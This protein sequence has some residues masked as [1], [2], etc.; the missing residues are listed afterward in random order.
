VLQEVRGTVG[1]LG[2]EARAGVDPHADRGRAGGEGGL[3]GDAEAIGK[4]GDARLRG[5]EN[6][7][8]VGERG[9]GRAVF[10][11]AGVLVFELAELVLDGLGSAVVDHGGGGRRSGRRGGRGG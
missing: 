6:V 10:E 4:R 3:G 2:L 7:R 5:G 1:L 9:A 8:V 11:E